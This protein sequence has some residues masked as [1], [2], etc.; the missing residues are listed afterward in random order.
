MVDQ[1]AHFAKEV[2]AARLA[3]FGSSLDNLG[4]FL[5]DLGADRLHATGQQLTRI[6]FL[7]G[8]GGTGSDCPFQFVE[9]LWCRAH[10]LIA[11]PSLVPG[12]RIV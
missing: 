12:V 7:V 4:R 8:I 10:G 6:R 2:F 9:W 5:H 3:R 11:F 1:V